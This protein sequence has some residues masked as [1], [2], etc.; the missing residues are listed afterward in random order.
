MKIHNVFILGLAVAV[1]LTLKAASPVDLSP[2]KELLSIPSVSADVAA[3]DKAI[4]W[5]RGCLESRGVWC[6]VETFPKDRR[7]ILY[8]ATKPGLKAPDYVL[9]THLD[10]VAPASPTQF[11][12]VEREGH[13][14]AR[15]ACDTKVNAFCG[16]E[17]LIRLN[18][19]A[20]VGCVFA[21][22]EEIGGN[23]TKHMVS[24]G[25]GH[26]QKAVVVLDA[27]SMSPDVR[28][29]CKGNAYY[30][31]T[32]TG[33]SGHSARPEACDNPIYKLAEA[34]MKIRDAYPHQKPGEYGNVASVTIIGGGDSQNRIPETASMTVNVRFVS[35][36][37]E[38]Q[39]VLVEHIT[40]LKTELIRGTDAAISRPDDP[41]ILRMQRLMKAAYPERACDIVR[42]L[43]ANDSR[44]FPQFGKP[45]MTVSMDHDGGHT[46]N[47][48]CSVRDIPRFIGL[49]MAYLAPP[50]VI[51]K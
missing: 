16:A 39:R 48:W 15:G 4:D 25:Y 20:S 49:L 30:K 18:G 47:E 17:A 43:G 6:V 34:A 11:V 26:P 9:V 12:P 19:R 2:I 10:V 42:G 31:V 14:Y 8:A 3:N 40:G 50:D 24:L 37:L 32:A 29:A 45:M 22:D 28:Y 41:E 27:G 36:G 46:D 13:L 21:S 38:D 5:M 44:Y 1:S 33:K 7:K 23:T 51:G 35:G